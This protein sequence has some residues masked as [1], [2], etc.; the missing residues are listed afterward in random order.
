MGY[1]RSRL[2]AVIEKSTAIAVSGLRHTFEGGASLSF[3]DFEVNQNEHLLLFGNSGSG[4]TTLLHLLA[5]LIRI[6]SGDIRL[7][8][9]SLKGLS[10]SQLDAFRG[11]HIGLVFQ[12]ARF[13]KSLSVIEN[14]TIAQY[15]G[16]SEVNEKSALALLSELKIAHLA[17]QSTAALSGGERQRLGIARAL[18]VQPSI[19]LADEPTSSLDD[20]NTEAVAQLLLREADAYK[21]ALIVV[22]HDSRL[23]THFKNHLEI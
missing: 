10:Q 3:P 11:E 22:S 16:R 2:K 21:A 1:F 13:I 20:R 4:K 5:G 7:L 6:Q 12:Q 19:I 15:F 18:A 17:D 9:Q 8:N 14:I 23:R